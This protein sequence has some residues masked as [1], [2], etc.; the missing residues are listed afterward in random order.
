MPQ[1]IVFS[2]AV[3]GLALVLPATV[4]RLVL[5]RLLRPHRPDEEALD[6]AL[7][8]GPVVGFLLA[9]FPGWLLSAAFLVPIDAVVLPAGTIALLAAVLL[10]RR[11]LP[12]LLGRPRAWLLPAA[13]ILGT[14]LFFVWLREPIF[15]VHQTEKPMDLAVLSALLSTRSLPLGD[16]W[17]AGERFPYYHFGTYVLS[18]PARVAGLPPGV[19]YNLIAAVVPA[20]AAGAAFGAVRLKGGGRTLASGAALALVLAGTFDGARQLLAGAPLA[21]VDL[22]AS[23][24]RVAGAITEW[25]LFTFRLGDLHPH[26]L[27]IPFLLALV[28]IA[29]AVSG[30]KGRLLEG[31]LLAALV[32]ANPWDLPAGVLV[33]AAAHVASRPPLAAIRSVATTLV[34]AVVLVIPTLLAPRPGFLGLGR[35]MGETAS[36]EAF[37]HLGPFLAIPALGIGVAL[38]RSR[39]AGDERLFLA[40][41]FPAAGIAL[42]VVTGKPVLGLALAFLGAVESVRPSLGLGGS[43]ARGCLLASVAVVLLAL[44]EVVVVRDP[45]G[46]EFRRMNTL[47]KS[48]SA[49]VPLLVVASALLVP[50]PLAT[51]RGRKTVR[52]LLGV[53]LLGATVHPA[54]AIASRLMTRPS[55]LDGLSAMSPGDRTAAAWLSENAPPDAIL[56]EA[57]G[58]QYGEEGRIGAA[59]GRPVV[60]GWAGHERLWRGE[61][62]ATAIEE[63]RRDLEVLYRSTD[64]V[65]VA[66][67]LSRRRVSFIVVGAVERRAFG[68]D[69]FPL[70]T[71][72]ENVLPRGATSLYR[73]IPRPPFPAK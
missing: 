57:P 48:W 16:P 73:V 47:F 25:P 59:S 32:S 42:A 34:P 5:L 23:S 58:T 30:W 35:A 1:G 62:G 61:E 27:A 67:I 46:P 70:R 6:G 68:E 14:L 50:L 2:T 40:T 54:A 8:L 66:A 15:A 29:A 64:S 49:A 31:S 20:L 38:V 56:A 37:L 33:V 52:L 36:W 10:C 17:M 12:R 24:R 26:A 65:A 51:R 18:L 22:W 4:G 55:T 13:V 71:R 19:A 3:F 69:A 11:D 43:L 7:G 9:A 53:V 45:Y 63:H 39:A 21:S 44:P 28:G 41:V 72:H 60:L